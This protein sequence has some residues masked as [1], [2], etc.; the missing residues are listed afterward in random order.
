MS[1]VEKVCELLTAYGEASRADWLTLDGRTVRDVMN[2]FAGLLSSEK[3]VN[4]EEE[5]KA[6][7]IFKGEWGYEWEWNL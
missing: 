2:R 3:D 7:G 6:V 1:N 4:V 5:L